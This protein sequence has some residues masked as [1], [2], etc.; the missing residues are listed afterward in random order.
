MKIKLV[1]ATRVSES[2]FYTE[3]ATGRSVNFNKPS[4][5]EI[6]T[7]C[8]NSQGLPAVYNQAI[9]ECVRDPA[10]LVFAHDDLHF[11]DYFWFNRIK[12]G[13]TKF[14]VIGLAGNKR[15]LPMQPSWLF[16]D[17]NFTPDRLENLSGLVGHG[18]AFPPSKLSIYGAPRQKVKMLDGLLIAAESETL[19]KNNLHFDE[20]FDFNFYDLDFCRAAELKGLSCG[21]WDL[22]VIHES[23]GKFGSNNWRENYRRYI[24]KWGD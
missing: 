7:F 1:V 12:S 11:L 20:R 8:N 5:L 22:S 14:D 19:L 4:F 24:E 15:R 16:V 18:R 6:R 2:E 21:T 3:K 13:L 17:E 23:H 9:R 10:T